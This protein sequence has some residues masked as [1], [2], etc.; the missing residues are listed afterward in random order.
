MLVV[1][2]VL[3]ALAGG[4]PGRQWAL[5]VYC[6]SATWL[7]LVSGLYHVGK[8]TPGQRA[9]LRRTDHANIFVLVAGTYT[10][11]TVALL[12]GTW[13]VVI[14][15]VVWGIAVVGGAIVVAALGIPRGLLAGMYLLQGW[16]ALAA[17]PAIAMAV[18]GGGLAVLLAGGA[19]YTA[20]AVCYALRRPD[21]FPDWFGYHEVF[22]AL[23]IA[24][25]AC[26]VAFMVAE[27]VRRP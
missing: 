1:G 17:M 12:G 14:L 25:N 18:G 22:H 24:A 7:F 9:L 11:V 3:V 10:P 2:L 15:A 16:V 6:L 23:V 20:G 19:L 27:V 13:R 4:H 8:W 21:P 26:F 5:L